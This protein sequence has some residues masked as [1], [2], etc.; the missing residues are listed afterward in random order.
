MEEK[1]I[2]L[3]NEVYKT[4]CDALERRGWAFEKD[5]EKLLV[6]FGVSGEDLPMQFLITLDVSR[7]LICLI[8]PLPFKMSE[9][10]RVEG[11]IAVCTANF[12]M[13]DGR[14]DYDLTDGTIL[15][16]VNASF[17]ESVIGE[18]LMQYL[19][20]CACVTV[21]KYNEKFLAIDKGAL[22]ITDF[23]K[24]EREP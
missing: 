1:N 22:S 4:L 5:E 10:K 6:H 23:I 19:I 13:A 8:S 20:S 17:K 21:D 9:E 18:G 3:A 16:R 14:F 15:F 11:A 12:G 2:A 7:Q 24:G